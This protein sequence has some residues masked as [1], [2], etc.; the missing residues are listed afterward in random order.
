MASSL[1]LLAVGSA[2]LLLAAGRP[3]RTH[4]GFVGQRSGFPLVTNV[5]TGLSLVP[6]LS[7]LG[8]VGLAG[9]LAVLATRGWVRVAS[10]VVIAATGS[11]G[12]ALSLTAPNGSGGGMV[13]GRLT[14]WPF[15]AAGSA[16]LVALS[17]FAIA[18]RGRGWV[19][20]S[21]KYE[22]PATRAATPEQGARSTWEAMDR[23]EDPT[24]S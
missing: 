19:G 15:V 11:L 9:V 7:A 16:V 21:G 20:M 17:G 5:R 4:I 13:A 10:G 18:L 24:E 8:L 23:G 3:W 2:L 12:V 22:T 6:G 1:V 14:S